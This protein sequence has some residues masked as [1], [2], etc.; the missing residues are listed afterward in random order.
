M[1]SKKTTEK[2]IRLTQFVKTKRHGHIGRVMGIANFFGE[3][4]E[5][6]SWFKL[7]GLNE[8][9]KDE[10]WVSILI[11]NGGAAQVPESDV[12]IIESFEFVN[13]Y[14]DRYFI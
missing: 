10:R 8:S 13:P 4:G 5:S 14:A 6:N 12:E 9:A 1:T 7:Q 11:H 2:H 3:T